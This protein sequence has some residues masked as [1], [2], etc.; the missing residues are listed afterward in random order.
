MKN[1]DLQV[2]VFPKYC[3]DGPSKIFRDLAGGLLLE[4]IK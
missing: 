4:T 3:I 1:N 2:I